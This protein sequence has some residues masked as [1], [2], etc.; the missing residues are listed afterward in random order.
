MFSLP[1]ESREAQQHEITDQRLHPV[2][3]TRPHDRPTPRGSVAA[4]NGLAGSSL[5]STAG[6]CT[7]AT[8]GLGALDDTA[9]EGTASS[10]ETSCHGLIESELLS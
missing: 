3:A 10:G 4:P 8:T 1:K 2:S 5:C 6:M 7:D 9:V